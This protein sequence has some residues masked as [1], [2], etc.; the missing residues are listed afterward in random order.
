MSTVIER[1]LGGAAGSVVTIEPDFIVIN[2]GV[3]H[4]AVEEISSVADPEKVYVI[5]DHDVPTGRPEAAAIL[6]K[7][8][9][10]ARKY[11]CRY[12]QARGIGY[13]YM[14]REVAKPGQVVI[15][16]GSHGAIYGANGVL[17][18]D[19]SIPELARVAETGRFSTVIPETVSVNLR[20]SFPE[21]VGAMD[22][23]FAFLGE[24]R[25][26]LTK[27]AVEVFAPG[28]TRHEK[29]VFLSIVGSS[30]AYTACIRD[31]EAENGL[32]LDLSKLV[33]MVMHPCA[34][35][36][37][38]KNARI[39]EKAAIAGTVLQAGQI[40]GCTGGTIEDLR[41]TAAL[42]KGKK[43]ALGFR[44]SICP[45]TAQDYIQACE[46]GL[47]TQL[48]DYGAQIQAAGDHSEVIQGAGAMGAD[49]TLLT[50]GLYTYSGAM[51]VSS[52]KVFSASVQSVALASVSKKI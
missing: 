28:L 42:L 39:T 26:K 36:R 35:R 43:L 22:A 8:L 19:V 51:G 37:D 48:I 50:T 21:G 40:G 4:A 27:K 23:A 33:P 9:Q 7:N 10:F 15:G 25:N 45:A 44:L 6:R 14:L 11:G 29:E 2:D 12:V 20:G 13:L 5:Y 17:G 49:E 47:I 31:S 52:A 3:S 46:E 34:D 1:I 30:G 38:Q 32:E 16:A 18:L 41:L 24:H